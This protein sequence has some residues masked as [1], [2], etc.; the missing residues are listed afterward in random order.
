A[1]K[2]NETRENSLSDSQTIFYLSET[3][4]DPAD[5]PDLLNNETP[6]NHINQYMEENIGGTRYSQYIGGGTANIEWSM[7]SSCSL[8][9]FN[10][11]MSVTPCSDI[12][13]SSKNHHT[14]LDYFANNEKAI[15][16]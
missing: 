1:K 2:V 4:M 14:V 15:L 6:I 8:E 3:L 13:S 12:D 11:P 9:V 7:L 16:T 10:D 5:V